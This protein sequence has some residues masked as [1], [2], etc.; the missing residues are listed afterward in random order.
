[1]QFLDH[2]L[3]QCFNT[4]I[5]IDIFFGS[6]YLLQDILRLLTLWFNHG[7]TAEVQMALRKGFELVNINTWLVVL[8]QIIARIH[9]NNHAVRELIQS[10][11]VRIGQSHPQV[12][13]R[14][15]LC[16]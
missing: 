7:D 4:M 15:F 9:S 16:V 2:A 1:M 8:P 14:L 13:F 10:L 5:L 12:C 3:L 6:H 11:L